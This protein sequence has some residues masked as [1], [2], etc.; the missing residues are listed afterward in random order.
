MRST[1]NNIGNWWCSADCTLMMM[2]EIKLAVQEGGSSSD[3]GLT[4][5][6]IGTGCVCRGYAGCK[7]DGIAEGAVWAQ[8]QG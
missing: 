8:A 4:K 1:I 3:G 2:G 7:Q 5:E 6:H